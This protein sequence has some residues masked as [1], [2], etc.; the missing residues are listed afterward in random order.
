ML[1]GHVP[2]QESRWSNSY[3]RQ[4]NKKAE[5]GCKAEAVVEDEEIVS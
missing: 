1:V 5:K 3:G 2:S 4:A